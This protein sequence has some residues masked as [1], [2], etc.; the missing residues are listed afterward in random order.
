MNLNFKI[1]AVMVIAANLIAIAHI[2]TSAEPYVSEQITPHDWVT[3]GA[4]L[5]E[6]QS[7]FDEEWSW[8]E[9]YSICLELLTNGNMTIERE[10]Q[11]DIMII[12]HQLGD[13]IRL[14]LN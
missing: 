3:C 8:D 6:S 14:E 10:N 13:T 2:T 4:S 12:W 9:M 7:A 5:Q 1:I 11:R